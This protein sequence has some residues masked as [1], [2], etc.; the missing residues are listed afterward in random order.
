[1]T[2][3]IDTKAPAVPPAPALL[4]GSDSGVKGDNI[5]NSTTPTFTGAAEAGQHGLAVQRQAN[6]VGTA[7]AT[8]DGNWTI[9][10]VG[11]GERGPQS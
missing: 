8:A 6:K 11:D 10:S 4:A 3:V 5:T 1:M 9:T 7:L 2:L